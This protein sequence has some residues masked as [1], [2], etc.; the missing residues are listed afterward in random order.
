[1]DR[2]WSHSIRRNLRIG[3]AKAINTCRFP[4]GTTAKSNVE[5]LHDSCSLGTF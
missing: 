3:I 4:K 2:P 1:M 5:D